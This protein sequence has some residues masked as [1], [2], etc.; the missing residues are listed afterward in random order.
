[1]SKYIITYITMG[2]MQTYI[3]GSKMG[4][5]EFLRR[6]PQLVMSGKYQLQVLEISRECSLKEFFDETLAA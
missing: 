1:V 6:H 3:L 4:V 5:S 2:E